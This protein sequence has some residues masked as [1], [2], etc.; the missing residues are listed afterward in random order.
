VNAERVPIWIGF[1]SS[2][3]K[4][5]KASG[6]WT[7]GGEWWDAKTK[8]LR[9]EWDVDIALDGRPDLQLTASSRNYQHIVGL[10]KE[11]MS[12]HAICRATRSVCILIS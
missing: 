9:E 1:K 10:S 2:E 3:R 12:S 5:I 7:N 11:R 6:P 4:I 8:W